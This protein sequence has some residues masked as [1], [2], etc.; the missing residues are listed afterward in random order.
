M[1]VKYLEANDASGKYRWWTYEM[2]S[3]GQFEH[4]NTIPEIK[5][6][7]MAYLKK[8]LVV[9]DAEPYDDEEKTMTRSRIREQDWK[10]K[11]KGG[12]SKT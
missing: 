8:N 11:Q 6:K 9:V 7:V 2:E 3:V 4:A 12:K 1:T 10:K 5:E